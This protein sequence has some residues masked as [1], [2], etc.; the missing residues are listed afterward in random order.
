MSYTIKA[1]MQK[2]FPTE[3]LE[4]SVEGY[5]YHYVARVPPCDNAS[6]VYLSDSF[7]A[8]RL[9]VFFL[10]VDWNKYVLGKDQEKAEMTYAYVP[11]KENAENEMACIFLPD[12]VGEIVMQ[13]DAVFGVLVGGPYAYAGR[14]AV[15]EG[16]VVR[17]KSNLKFSKVTKI[18]LKGDGDEATVHITDVEDTS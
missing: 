2:Q 1:L 12:E 16:V 18:I 4:C 6:N 5:Y 10:N 15:V 11:L 7:G 9:N 3:G 13:E 14:D 17:D 8:N